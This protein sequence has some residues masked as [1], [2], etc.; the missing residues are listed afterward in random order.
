MVTLSATGHRSRHPLGSSF[1]DLSTNR[2]RKASPAFLRFRH[3]C[4]N[5]E[6][7]S[8]ICPRSLDRLRRTAVRVAPENW[9]NAIG[10]P[11]A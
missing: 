2:Y 7:N 5:L 11:M 3:T 1:Q 9:S 4:Q 6:Q 8:T 10:M